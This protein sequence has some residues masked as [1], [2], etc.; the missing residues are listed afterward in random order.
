ANDD[1]LGLRNGGRHDG[2]L[3]LRITLSPALSGPPT[4]EISSSVRTPMATGFCSGWPLGPSTHTVPR[5]PLGRFSIP[6]AGVWAAALAALP[7]ARRPPIPGGP[8][9]PPGGILR[10]SCAAMAAGL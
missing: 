3:S 6:G 10:A 4:T 1:G 7:A 8:N 2:A 9:P 5:W